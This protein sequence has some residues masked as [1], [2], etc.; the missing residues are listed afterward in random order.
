LDC[1]GFNSMSDV[2]DQPSPNRGDVAH[3]LTRLGISLVPGVGGA[4]VELF[5][6]LITPP[7]VIRRNEWLSKFLEELNKRVSN[8]EDVVE[9]PQFV[10]AFLQAL[11]M[12]VRTHQQ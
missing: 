7:V 10:T 3:F 8:L 6:A 9:N 2:P 1:Q 12:A 11:P 4:G 5:N